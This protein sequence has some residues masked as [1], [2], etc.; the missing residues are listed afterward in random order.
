MP[1]LPCWVFASWTSSSSPFTA[2]IVE[3]CSP[4]LPSS[5]KTARS[6][7]WYW[8]H[9]CFR[10]VH[11]QFIYVPLSPCND[12]CHSFEHDYLTR[13]EICRQVIYIY[14][15]QFATLPFSHVW[16][17]MMSNRLW[18]NIKMASVHHS[19]QWNTASFLRLIWFGFEQPSFSLSPSF[20]GC[21][22]AFDI[23][24]LGVYL[25]VRKVSN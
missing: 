1:T 21:R 24:Y 13:L 2:S 14:K 4:K 10:A 19:L 20:V 6:E 8:W 18:N 5:E 3:V 25:S 7:A 23:K 12:W 9:H 22:V 17:V 11:H 16:W 15:W